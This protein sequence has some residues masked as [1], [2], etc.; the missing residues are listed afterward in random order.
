MGPRVT[1]PMRATQQLK[2][3]LR[4]IHILFTNF[5]DVGL[6]ALTEFAGD[7]ASQYTSDQRAPIDAR[8]SRGIG[9]M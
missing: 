1:R 9:S 6:I 4:F 8:R 7:V 3:P 2:G 5:S